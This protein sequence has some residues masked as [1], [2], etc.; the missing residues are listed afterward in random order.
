M[1]EL[2]YVLTQCFVF[3]AHVRFYFPLALIYTLMAAPRWPLAFLIFSPPLWIFMFFFLRNSSPLFSVT[4]SSSF[5]VIHLSVN[6][7]YNVEKD[8]TLLLFFSQS[9]GGHELPTCRLSYST[10]VCLWCE[11]SGGRVRWL[12]KISKFLGYIGYQIFSPMVL[13]FA[14]FAR[15]RASL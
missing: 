14:R 2:S 5:S 6:I 1:E 8:T 7:K 12:L 9:P 11:R 10:L 4:R 15:E 13:R 3:C